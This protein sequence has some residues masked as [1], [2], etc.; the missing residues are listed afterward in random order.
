M[1]LVSKVW[2]D[3]PMWN[4]NFSKIGPSGVIFSLAH[5][6]ELEVVLLH[7]LEYWVKVNASEYAKYYFLLQGMLCQSGL[8]NVEL[9]RLRPMDVKG[10]EVEARWPRC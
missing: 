9:T 3:L 6:N 7:A 10:A 5:T 1:V 8:A 4:C 2:D